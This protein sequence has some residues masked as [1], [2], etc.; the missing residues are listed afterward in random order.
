MCRRRSPSG[1]FSPH[2]GAVITFSSAPVLPVG[3]LAEAVARYERLGFT[4]EEFEGGG[5]RLCLPRGSHP[6]PRNRGT[7]PARPAEDRGVLSVSD[8]HA[9]HDEWREVVVDGR[10]IRRSTPTTGSSRGHSSTPTGPKQVLVDAR[11]RH[12]VSCTT[13]VETPRPAGDSYAGLAQPPRALVPPAGSVSARRCEGRRPEGSQAGSFLRCLRVNLGYAPLI[14][15]TPG[16]K[17]I[18]YEIS[19]VGDQ[20]VV[21]TRHRPDARDALA[22]Q[23]SRGMD[24]V[25]LPAPQAHPITGGPWS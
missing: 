11:P 6:A 22:D 1:T 4:L 16:L 17:P 9:L 7:G 5:C 15:S 21:S 25:A 20:P 19:H 3:H 8:A 13:G 2:A 12:A 14:S 10:L 24:A 23:S 18:E